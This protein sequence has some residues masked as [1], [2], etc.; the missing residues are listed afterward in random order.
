ML[1]CFVVKGHYLFL[2]HFTISHI[3]AQ[4]LENN[5][6]HIEGTLNNDDSSRIKDVPSCTALLEE[7]TSVDRTYTGLFI[8]L[9]PITGVIIGTIVRHLAQPLQAKPFAEVGLTLAG[10]AASLASMFYPSDECEIN[11]GQHTTAAMW[12]LFSPLATACLFSGGILFTGGL[13]RRM[14]PP[15][16]QPLMPTATGGA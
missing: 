6:E 11:S 10:A 8:L 15:E 14:L 3:S 4:N 5:H 13:I 16:L 7:F 1:L 2:L 12:S 9:P